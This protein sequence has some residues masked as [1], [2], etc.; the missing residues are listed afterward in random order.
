MSDESQ[1][2]KEEQLNSWEL[3]SGEEVFVTGS[4]EEGEQPL[5]TA[6]R[7]LLEE[8][9]YIA[10][11]W[12]SVGSFVVDENKGCTKSHSFIAKRPRKVVEPVVDDMEESKIVF[13]SNE[14]IMR[15]VLGGE[16]STLAAASFAAIVTNPYMLTLLNGDTKR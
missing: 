7:E 10:G 2:K 6:Q 8:T 14:S 3:L 11:I 15:S 5:K 13:V 16:I 4:L 12:R 9:G 1:E